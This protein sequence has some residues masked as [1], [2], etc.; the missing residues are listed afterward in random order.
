MYI[1]IDLL[2]IGIGIFCLIKFKKPKNYGSVGYVA[3]IR[4][5]YFYYLLIILGTIFLIMEIFG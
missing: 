1:I 3:E 5:Y 4:L 2:M